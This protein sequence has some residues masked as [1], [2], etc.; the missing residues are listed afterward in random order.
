MSRVALL[1]FVV[2][3]EALAHPGHDAPEPHIHSI[4]EAV[5]LVALI[6]V[7]AILWR[8]TRS[9]HQRRKRPSVTENLR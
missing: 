2:F 5:L 9:S 1:F 4:R 8:V 7:C 3:V 6:V